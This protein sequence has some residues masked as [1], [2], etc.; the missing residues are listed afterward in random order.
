MGFTDWIHGNTTAQ[1]AGPQ[2]AS[3]LSTWPLSVIHLDTGH[4]APSHRGL[5]VQGDTGELAEFRWW[6]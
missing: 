5:P 1:C 6:W 4:F 2:A 3:L